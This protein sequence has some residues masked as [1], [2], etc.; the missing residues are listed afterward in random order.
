MPRLNELIPTCIGEAEDGDATCDGDQTS[1]IE[2]E[3]APCSWRERCR[4]FAMRLRATG[5]T[6]GDHIQLVKLSGQ[7][8]RRSGLSETARPL[9]LTTAQFTRFCRTALATY[10]PWRP[11]EPRGQGLAAVPPRSAILVGGRGVSV[12]LPSEGPRRR[13]ASERER[14]MKARREAFHAMRA[15]LLARL[16]EELPRHIQRRSTR[17]ILPGDFHLDTDWVRFRCTLYVRAK[18]DR[19]LLRIQYAPS[20]SCVTVWVGTDARRFAAVIS[21]KT[22]VRLDPKP[23]TMSSFPVVIRNANDEALSLIAEALGRL[24]Q[25]GILQPPSSKGEARGATR[26]RS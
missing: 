12:G 18:S 6:A 2:H 8:K 16:D 25:R 7:V 15:W 10:G 17:L 5:E 21:R 26:R 13:S 3:R 14:I 23:T 9:H 22:L 1:S 24:L 4:G 11:T 20:T 19:G